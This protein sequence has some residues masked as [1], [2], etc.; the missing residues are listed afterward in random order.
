M[1]LLRN[2]DAC[3]PQHN[4]QEPAANAK[5]MQSLQ[6]SLGLPQPGAPTRSLNWEKIWTRDRSLSVPVFYSL[7]QLS[8]KTMVA[9]LQEGGSI[10]ALDAVRKDFP[11]KLCSLSNRLPE[12]VS[13]KLNRTAD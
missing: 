10:R 2:G 3:I 4:K 9:G 11:M 7:L 1:T 12:P 6:S 13:A 5:K 8:R